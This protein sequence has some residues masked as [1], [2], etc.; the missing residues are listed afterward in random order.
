MVARVGDRRQRHCCGFGIAG[1]VRGL[2]DSPV[3]GRCGRQGIRR[4]LKIDIEVGPV[5]QSHCDAVEVAVERRPRAPCL[6][7]QVEDALA[8]IVDGCGAG[9]TRVRVRGQQRPIDRPGLDL[10]QSRRAVEAEVPAVVRVVE[11]QGVAAVSVPSLPAVE[12][13]RVGGAALQVRLGVETLAVP[14]V[15]GPLR[16]QQ[17]REVGGGHVAVVVRVVGDRLDVAH[18]EARPKVE[19]WAQVHLG[20]ARATGLAEV[21][22]AVTHGV[23]AVVG[24]HSRG[25]VA[26]TL[27][28]DRH[29]HVGREGRAHCVIAADVGEGDRARDARGQAVNSQCADV[30]S[31]I[32]RD[33]DRCAVAPIHG[34]ARGRDRAVARAARGDRVGSRRRHRS[35]VVPVHVIGVA[36]VVGLQHDVAEPDAVRQVAVVAVGECLRVDEL[37]VDVIAERAGIAGRGWVELHPKLVP[38]T[39]G[40]PVGVADVDPGA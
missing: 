9:G 38:A 6:E 16:V 34:L 10:R 21:P 11:G 31:G 15:C 22:R 19:G 12:R 35:D 40:E 14:A 8:R 20:L 28:Q 5:L 29:V 3:T 24:C 17:H 23:L 4:G 18:R 1:E 32:R 13:R 7:A 33:G 37:V 30:V 27:Q 26:R 39:V 2:G 36:V 25:C